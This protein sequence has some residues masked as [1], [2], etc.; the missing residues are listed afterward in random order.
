MAI[1]R[2]VRLA[3]STICFAMQ[4]F[5]SAAKRASLPES[6]FKWRLADLLSDF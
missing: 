2:F 1:P 3:F 4:W 5:T 6:F